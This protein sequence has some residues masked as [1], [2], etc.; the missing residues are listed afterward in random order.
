MSK[1]VREK[2]KNSNYY[3]LRL[4]S[5]ASETGS[6]GLRDDPWSGR[7]FGNNWLPQTRAVYTVYRNMIYFEEV[8]AYGVETHRRHLR[9]Y[10]R[11]LQNNFPPA[12]VVTT[13][14]GDLSSVGLWRSG[15]AIRVETHRNRQHTTTLFR[16]PNGRQDGPY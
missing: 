10:V 9:E 16:N 4:A 2:V 14:V 3:S 6:G 13:F 11:N 5:P 8:S 12:R 1:L 15:N 7:A